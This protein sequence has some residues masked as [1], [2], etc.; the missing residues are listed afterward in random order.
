MKKF[1]SS[2]LQIGVFGTIF[3]TLS[4]TANGQAVSVR[5][6]NNYL[7]K[8]DDGKNVSLF[9]RFEISYSYTFGAGS[10]NLNDRFR[11]QSN[12]NIIAGHSRSTTF[13]YRSASGYAGV[14]FPLS[15]LSNNS[16]LVLNT[17]LY[18]VGNVWHLGNIS[19]TDGQIRS[20]DAADIF[21]GAALGVDYVFG[22]EATLNKSDKV[23][24]R[25]GAGLMP[26]FAVGD[27]ADG[28]NSYGKLGIKP[29]VKA[30]LGF[31][32]GVE[33]KIKGMAVLGSRTVYDIKTGDYNLGDSDYYYS[34]NFKIRPTYS[35]GIAVM[36][37]SFGWES[38]KW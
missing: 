31:F 22:G 15:Y 36:P 11:D 29:Y 16:A 24:L 10:L 30:E 25:A 21:F 5:D 37:F 38:D 1:F 33:W 13:N 35:I 18:Y 27:L 6:I 34:M 8:R 9:H 26:Y 7:K 14:Y 23:T 20:Y 28:S 19:L 32:A 2:L 3:A 4:I 17:G 12:N